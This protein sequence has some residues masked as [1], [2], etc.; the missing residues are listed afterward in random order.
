MSLTEDTI[1]LRIGKPNSA[2]TRANVRLTAQVVVRLTLRAQ[3]EKNEN[4]HFDSWKQ[5]FQKRPIFSRKRT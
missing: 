4:I 2:K 5:R 3:K 1:R